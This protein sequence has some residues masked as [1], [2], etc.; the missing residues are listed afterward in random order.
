MRSSFK[1]RGLSR[2]SARLEGLEPRTLFSTLMVN[3]T[4]GADTIALGVTS[5]G[6]VKVTLNGVTTEYQPGQWTDVAV[7]TKAGDDSVAVNASV[8]PIGIVNGGG[9]DTVYVGGGT[10]AHILA[11][12]TVGSLKVGLGSGQTALTVDGSSSTTPTQFTLSAANPVG[13][14]DNPFGTV[15]FTIGSTAS[16]HS[17]RFDATQTSSVT[18]DGGSGGNNFF[19]EGTPGA[20]SATSPAPAITLN[21]GAGNDTIGVSSVAAGTTLT[22]NGQAG[23]DTLTVTP[24][25]ATGGNIAFDGGDGNNRVVILGNLFPVV[26]L[27][28]SPPPDA[29][30]IV[31]T[32]GQAKR[33]NA[34]IDY[35]HTQT[36]QV[37][38]GDFLA[39]GNLGGITLVVGASA[40]IVPFPVTVGVNADQTLYG[41]DIKSGLVTLNDHA[42]LSTDSLM[43][44]TGPTPVTG[45]IVV[46]PRGRLDV[47]TSRL[48][49][50]Y[51]ADDPFAQ[52]RTWI[53][54]GT[55]FSSS[56]DARHNV[57]YADS[58]DGV[59]HG[60]ADHTVLAQFALDG[61]TNLDGTVNFADLLRLAQ[62]YGKNSANWDQGDF[63]YD[64]HVGF[65]DLLKLAQN[66]GRSLD[67]PATSAALAV[68]ADSA[69]VKRRR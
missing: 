63:N 37:E 66:Y 59:V 36:L 34:T 57:G 26:P 51:G 41:L 40:G 55:I 62:N 47:G 65:D 28:V 29:N 10:L 22:I 15:A 27:D 4:A 60:L 23:D 50:H 44:A 14:A 17:V 33:G 58:A 9:T 5:Q 19:V 54:G 52:I 1:F 3:G 16:Q 35:T 20:A 25:N 64:G 53:F 24:F 21:T 30:S 12:V 42:T 61:D 68:A 11:D 56:A 49:V 67:S 38:E 7:N 69:L 32:A 48:D 8:V 6:G 45:E 31:L 39:N 43:I 13:P 18:V 2:I 46:V